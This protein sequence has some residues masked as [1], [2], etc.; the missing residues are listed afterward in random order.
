MSARHL[1]AH[2]NLTNLRNRAKQLLK[3]H[4]AGDSEAWARWR[5]LPQFEK[6]TDAELQSAPVLL[7]DAQSVIARE[8]GFDSWRHLKHH[9]ET[10]DVLKALDRAIDAIDIGQVRRLLQGSPELVHA[11]LYSYDSEE[12]GTVLGA[13]LMSRRREENYIENRAV[14]ADQVALVGAILRAGATLDEP[15][16][17]GGGGLAPLAIA[18]WLGKFGFVELLLA[19]GADP[20]SE[21]EPGDTAIRVAADHN[22]TAI[23]ERLIQ[24]GARFHI[25]Q[26]AQ[27]GLVNRLEVWLDQHPER[28]NEA[29]DLGHRKGRTGTSL[30]AALDPGR[31]IRRVPDYERVILLLLDRGIDVNA[32][33]SD[34]RMALD[35]ARQL[36]TPMGKRVVKLLLEHGAKG[37]EGPGKS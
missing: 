14:T 24:A 17:F 25:G 11:R 28:I 32:V 21:P 13:A 18:A 3:A 4:Q 26:L 33:D 30:H 19:H 7:A 6:F 5:R 29:V 15:T 23:V 9:I 8:Y 20:N 16:G 37:E 36:D 27:A 1:P 31:P 22:H 10:P 34:G 35:Y 2:P 12:G